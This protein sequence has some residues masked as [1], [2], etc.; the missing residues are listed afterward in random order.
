[1]KYLL[2]I[3]VLLVSNYMSAQDTTKVGKDNSALLNTEEAALL[4]TLLQDSRGNFDFTYKRAV[5]VTGSTGK[6]IV[7]KSDYFQK[8]VLPW[9]A[10]GGTPQILKIELTSNEKEEA[11]GYDVI[12]LSWVKMFTQKSKRG[13]VKSLA[14]GL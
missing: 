2:A 4:N 12:V 9:I 7:N 11:G 3:L 6:R 1:M 5:F 8:L 14:K 13:L 10:K